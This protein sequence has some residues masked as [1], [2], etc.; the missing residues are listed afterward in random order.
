MNLNLVNLNPGSR[1]QSRR[2]RIPC[3]LRSIHEGPDT[4]KTIMLLAVAASLLVAV[5][6]PTASVGGPMTIMFV[7]FLAMLT[8]GIYE[9]WSNRRGPLGWVVNIVVAV[10]GGFVA[11]SFAGLAIIE[12]IIMLFPING[13]LASS[14]HP[15]FYVGYAGMAVLTVLGSW[16]AIQI[17][18][19]FRQ[20]WMRPQIRS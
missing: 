5:F 11:A 20:M 12:P 17:V 9:A 14:G 18:N 4:L 1:D 7:L 2:G 13:S 6:G 10:I 15:L 16:I 19:K 3:P 8:V